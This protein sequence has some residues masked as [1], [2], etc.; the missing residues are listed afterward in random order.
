MGLSALFN[1]CWEQGWILNHCFI[2]FLGCIKF[3]FFST[4]GSRKDTMPKKKYLI[5]L[6]P[7]HL[8]PSLSSYS[9]STRVWH[10]S[11]LVGWNQ[12]NGSLHNNNR[13][14]RIQLYFDLGKQSWPW[15]KGPIRL[16]QGFFF[17]LLP[18]GQR[19]F[20]PF[21]DCPSLS[22]G[23]WS[24]IIVSLLFCPLFTA[25]TSDSCN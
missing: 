1:C 13:P 21:N 16:Q 6:L 2:R 24:P 23:N 12:K 18:V 14:W 25:L 19:F 8:C 9:L 4:H 7:W 5:Q 3:C 11:Q 15:I 10:E 20:F 22:A 17:F